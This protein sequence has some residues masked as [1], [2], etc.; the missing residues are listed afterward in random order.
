V[1]QIAARQHGCVR[2]RQLVGSGLSRDGVGRRVERG[3]LHRVHRGV[4]RLGHTAP[5]IEA[6]YMAAVLA[7][8][9]GA[10]LSGPA[11]ACHYGI[12]KGG[13][14]VPEVTTP[15]DRRIPGV[16]S[17]RIRLAPRD[18]TAY[19]RIP[20]TTVPRTLVDI[21]GRFDFDD[22]AEICHVA[23]IRHGVRAKAVYVALARRPNAPGAGK[24]HDIFRGEAHITL[25]ELEREFLR[26]LRSAGLP[27]PRTNRPAGGRYVDCRWPEHRLTVE[28]D[29]YTYHHTRHAWEQDRQRERQARARGDEFRRYTW[30][31]VDEEP[32]PMLTDLRRL[33]DHPH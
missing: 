33:L 8:G 12:T 15:K 28:L 11:A 7:C 10:V 17:H 3:L 9:E 22:M 4:Y 18:V 14:P 19:R 25:S 16:M 23:E 24:L 31:D 1:A 5:S 29:S 26:L 13:P 32:E 2:F 6:S 30:L 21:A 20:I 27:L